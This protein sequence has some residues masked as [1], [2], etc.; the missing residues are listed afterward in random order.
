MPCSLVEVQGCTEEPTASAFNGVVI[1]S[2]YKASCKV[3]EPKKKAEHSF[4]TPV[5][6]YENLRRNIVDD[7]YNVFM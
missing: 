2:K 7:M 3:R 5:K 6:L 4:E 1:L